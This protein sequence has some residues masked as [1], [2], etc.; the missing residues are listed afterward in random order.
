MKDTFGEAVRDDWLEASSSGMKWHLYAKTNIDAISLFAD[1]DDIRMCIKHRLDFTACP[2]PV[3]RCY[4]SCAVL[5]NMLAAA[6]TAVAR[7][8]WTDDVNARL[9]DL[10]HLDFESTAVRGFKGAVTLQR[11]AKTA[12]HVKQ[13]ARGDRV[14]FATEAVAAAAAAPAADEKEV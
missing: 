10:I 5:E 8:V 4:Q 14:F 9:R 1:A 11:L 3:R 6:W 12:I 2:H 13:F 7:S